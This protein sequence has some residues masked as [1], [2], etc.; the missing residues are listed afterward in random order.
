MIREHLDIFSGFYPFSYLQKL[1]VFLSLKGVSTSLMCAE[2]DW[3]QM[4]MLAFTDAYY[5][6]QLLGRS[7]HSFQCFFFIIFYYI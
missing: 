2:K 1:E 3:M 5:P 6:L 4:G 7:P